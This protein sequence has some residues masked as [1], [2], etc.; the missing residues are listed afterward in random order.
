MYDVIIKNVKIIDGLKTPAYIDDIAISN[1]KIV[2]APSNE[3]KS[4]QIIDGTNLCVCPGFIDAHSHGDI[5]LGKDFTTLSKV[6]QGITTDI[7]GQ[8]G[9]TSFPVN[10]KL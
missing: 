6:S 8:C 4:S 1:G 7:A 2:L 10:P 9:F 5:A 3:E